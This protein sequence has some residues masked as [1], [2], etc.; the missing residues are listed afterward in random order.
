MRLSGL[1]RQGGLEFAKKRR[2]EDYWGNFSR[3]FPELY[4][5]RGSRQMGKTTSPNFC[6]PTPADA[7][8]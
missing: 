3:L 1:R 7:G 4:K 5:R 6:W 8:H 2:L